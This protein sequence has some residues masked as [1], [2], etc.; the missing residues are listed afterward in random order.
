MLC[1]SAG[2]VVAA[3]AIHAFTLT[4]VHSAQKSEIQEDWRVEAVGLRVIETRIKG[5]AAGY[6]P[7]AHAVLADGW[8]RY[9]PRL[10]LLPEVKLAR[11]GAIADWRLCADGVCQPISAYVPQSEPGTPIILRPCG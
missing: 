6:D 2:A 8:W 11:S 3:L 10:P 9:D 1:L 5:S 7:P 4:W